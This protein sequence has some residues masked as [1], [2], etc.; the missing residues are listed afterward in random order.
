[1]TTASDPPAQP[2]AAAAP[3]S[4]DFGVHRDHLLRYARRRLRDGALAEDM[5]QDVLAAV[6]SGQA[7]FSGR[8]SPRTWLLGI[9]KHKIVDAIRRRA[10][11]VSLDAML[12]G[13]DGTALAS[14]LID[15]ADPCLVAEQRQ[16]L[17]RV[18]ALLEGLP[19]PLRRAFELHVV[20]GHSTGEVCGA[21][22]ITPGNLW[23]R[24][25][26]VRKELAAA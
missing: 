15:V 25:H 8:S 18:Q 2:S 16:L 5:V 7:S 21:L 13:N 1:M 14:P 6:V 17:R 20:L 10:G 3:T 24:V 9:L 4:A 23:V 11:E 26:R 19:V 22:G 12:D